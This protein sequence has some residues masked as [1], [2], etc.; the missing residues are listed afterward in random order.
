MRFKCKTGNFDNNKYCLGGWWIRTY[1]IMPAGCFAK[2]S[3]VGD[4]PTT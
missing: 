1:K 4:Y 3:K 2:S